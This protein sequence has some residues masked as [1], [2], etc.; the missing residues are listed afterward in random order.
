VHI[1]RITRKWV[2]VEV[3]ATLRTGAAATIE[4]VDVAVLPSGH[5]PTDDTSWSPA[6]YAGGVATFLVA[7]PDA[8]SDGALVVPVDGCDVWGRV[9]DTPEV[10]TARLVQIN[11][12]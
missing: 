6:T 2:D 12:Y 1:S 9:T 8:V 10:D 4:G 5:T 3:T 7:G 11:V